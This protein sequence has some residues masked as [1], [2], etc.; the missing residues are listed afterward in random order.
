[1]ASSLGLAS[2]ALGTETAGSIIMPSS[3]NNLVGI[4]PSV[5]LTSRY[6]V[7]PV[8]EH[9]DTVGP[10]TRT[11][12]DG[13]I[14][15]SAI[16]GVDENDN[17]TSAIPFK[18]KLPDYVA[19]C[20]FHALQGKRIGI[21]RNAIRA[22]DKSHPV[23]QAFESALAILEDAG[24]TIVD[25]ANYTAIAEYGSRNTTSIVALADFASSIAEYLSILSY[26]PTGIKDIKSIRNFTMSYPSEEYPDRDTKS[27]D[28]IIDMGF[29]NTSPEFWEA[30]QT[31][32]RI[33]SLGGIP[34]VLK[35]HSLDALIVPSA[36][37]FGGFDISATLGLPIINVPL[38]A[39]PQD[40]PIQYNDRGD[41]VNVAPN[42]PFGI[43]F[44]G[45]KFTEELLIGLAY[46]FEQ[47]TRVRDKVL[48]YIQPETE[49]E[50][51]LGSKL[52][53]A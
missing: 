45:D 48:P 30:Y 32:Q 16:A 14:I 51:V 4:K 13:A 8:S 20:H 33:F 23:L 24:A 12:K 40:T 18:E 3:F 34:G 35:N 39:Y 43:S 28:A 22:A 6:L 42:I 44:L 38:G 5:G 41:L 21:P 7:V 52:L 9:Q 46:A 19:A 49:L 29:N 1:M 53:M 2:A 31:N 27:W 37:G 17:Y 10:M 26:N 50:D 11:V 25:N 47:R 15:L 36:F